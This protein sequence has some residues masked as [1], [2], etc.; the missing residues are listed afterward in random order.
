MQPQDQMSSSLKDKGVNGVGNS[1]VE[2]QSE[3]SQP[4]LQTQQ[5]QQ[6]QHQQQIQQ[7]QPQRPPA[8]TPSPWLSFPFK[9]EERSLSMRDPE[10]EERDHKELYESVLKDMRSIVSTNLTFTVLSFNDHAKTPK[11]ILPESPDTQSILRQIDTIRKEQEATDLKTRLD[12]RW[13]SD[14]R[15]FD[16]PPTVP[17]HG[18]QG[19]VDASFREPIIFTKYRNDGA[20]CTVLIDHECL[21]MPPFKGLDMEGLER[22]VEKMVLVDSKVGAETTPQSQVQAQAQQPLPPQVQG[23]GQAQQQL[24]SQVQGQAQAQAKHK[25]NSHLLK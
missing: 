24:P 17:L 9:Y 22:Q 4:P 2:Q 16:L 1:S 12:Q 5:Q 21:S 10:Q 19:A 13:L 11:F 14:L 3:Q 18:N 25:H 6:A 8:F 23:P 7:Q 15:T 20:K